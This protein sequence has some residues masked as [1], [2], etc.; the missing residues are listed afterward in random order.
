MTGDIGDVA[1]ASVRAIERVVRTTFVARADRIAHA[2]RRVRATPSPGARRAMPSSAPAA[3]ARAESRISVER[4]ERARARAR[5]AV[6][7]VGL[8]R[9]RASRS[10]RCAS[11]AMPPTPSVTEWCTFIANAA[12]SPS[13]RRGLR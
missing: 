4:A 8:A 1:G 9:R 3:C 2:S 12:R 11:S 13:G 5:R 10:T 6:V 7:V